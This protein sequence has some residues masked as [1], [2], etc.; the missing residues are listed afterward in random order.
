MKTTRRSFLTTLAALPFVAPLLARRAVAAPLP[1]P[2]PHGWGMVTHDEIFGKSVAAAVEMQNKIYQCWDEA[3]RLLW[4]N[5]L[6]W[7]IE[8]ERRAL[9]DYN[10]TP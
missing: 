10:K 3:P 9:E 2:P 4:P 6:S 8:E 1:A 7:T 5:K